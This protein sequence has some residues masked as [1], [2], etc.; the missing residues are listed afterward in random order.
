MKKCGRKVGLSLCLQCRLCQGIP[1]HHYGNL[2]HCHTHVP[3]QKEKQQKKSHHHQKMNHWLMTEYTIP[4]PT[5][6]KTALHVVK[7]TLHT[8][9]ANYIFHAQTSRQTLEQRFHLL[10]HT[11]SGAIL[12]NLQS[13]S[14]VLYS[15]QC[16][17]VVERELPYFLKYL[18]SKIFAVNHNLCIY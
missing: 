14:W 1:A 13:I 5:A 9:Y 11:N 3:G 4:S 10:H 8:Y 12:H 6:P 16:A 15:S 17:P 7:H 18:R 2:A